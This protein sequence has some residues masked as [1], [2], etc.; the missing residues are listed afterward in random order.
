MPAPSKGL[1][2]SEVAMATAIASS[3]ARTERVMFGAGVRCGC[4]DC[5][6]VIF[7]SPSCPLCVLTHVFFV[8]ALVNRPVA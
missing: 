2:Y 6:S 3:S 7:V 5:P 4:S 1:R 8:S